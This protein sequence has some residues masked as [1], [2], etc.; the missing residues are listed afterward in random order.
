VDEERFC[1]DCGE[2]GW[3]CAERTASRAR[4]GQV[5]AAHFLTRAQSFLPALA[6][7]PQVGEAAGLYDMMAD[8]LEP[9]TWG[10]GLNVTW[11]DPDLHSRYVQAV[12]NVRALHAR[13]AEHLSRAA[14]RL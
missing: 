6:G 2:N 8:T 1:P 9:Y 11:G 7:D 13:A 10:S 5:S 4:A 12:R 3:R 14:C